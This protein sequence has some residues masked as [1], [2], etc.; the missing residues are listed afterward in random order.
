MDYQFGILGAI[1]LV[2]CRNRVPRNSDLPTVT[3]CY[4]I[5][6]LGLTYG[7]SAY[8]FLQAQSTFPRA[9]KLR[10]ILLVLEMSTF[11]PI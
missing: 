4:R 10:F 8:C 11:I 6:V 1:G 5:G 9:T 3:L 7:P 2:F